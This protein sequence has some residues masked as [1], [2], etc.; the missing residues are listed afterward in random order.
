[1]LSPSGEPAQGTFIPGLYGNA[2]NPPDLRE[3]AEV[4]QFDDGGS[5]TYD[6]QARRYDIQLPSG[7]VSIKVGAS[8]VQVNDGAI[9]LQ[10]GAIN[11]TGNVVIDG[12]LTVRGDING[13]GR[14]IDTAGNTANHKH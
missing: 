12:P 1:M 5:L 6:W 10:A 8:A 13:G 3:H 2:G 14:I 7:N 11:L 9:S 4:W